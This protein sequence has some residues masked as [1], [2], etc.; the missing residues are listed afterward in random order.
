MEA[1]GISQVRLQ[2]Q[3][4][5]LQELLWVWSG[6]SAALWMFWAA[7]WELGVLIRG[8]KTKLQALG[9]HWNQPQLCQDTGLNVPAKISSAL[10][11][12]DR[13]PAVHSGEYLLLLGRFD[14]CYPDPMWGCSLSKS[15]LPGLSRKGNF[16]PGWQSLFTCSSLPPN[17]RGKMGLETW[18][19][20][21]TRNK[22][23]WKW[24]AVFF[25]IFRK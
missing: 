4:G 25:F 24:T 22:M 20:S 19:L 12:S 2:E 10:V 21:T 16:S 15:W 11:G 6:S 3:G 14:W 9:A 17:N 5:E 7:M 1:M 8:A 23:Q 13:V 18:L